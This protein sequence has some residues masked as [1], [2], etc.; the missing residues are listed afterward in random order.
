MTADDVYQELEKIRGGQ[1]G[2][3]RPEDVVEIASPED[4]PLHNR[5]EWDDTIAGREYRLWQA[6]ELILSVKVIIEGGSPEPMRA[7]VSLKED[8]RTGEGYRHL[9]DVRHDKERYR[10]LLREAAGEMRRFQTRYQN[11]SELK[12]IFE[13]ADV[14]FKKV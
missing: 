14:V 4:H 13:I 3:L 7:Y 2:L 10:T 1:G 5:F 9:D 12:P 6:R 11:L 8:R